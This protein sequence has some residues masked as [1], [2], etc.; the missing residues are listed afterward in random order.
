[1]FEEDWRLF[2]A[3]RVPSIELETDVCT[4]VCSWFVGLVDVDSVG[5]VCF[6]D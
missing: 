1:M 3:A 2:S 4:A 5:A 6:E